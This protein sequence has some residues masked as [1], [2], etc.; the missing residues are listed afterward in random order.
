MIQK[1]VRIRVYVEDYGKTVNSEVSKVWR[2]FLLGFPYPSFS[3]N[4]ERKN[5]C[6]NTVLATWSSA[7]P[8]TCPVK[9]EKFK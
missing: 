3:L 9:P 8:W 5:S 1:E 2:L 7:V 6:I 4:A